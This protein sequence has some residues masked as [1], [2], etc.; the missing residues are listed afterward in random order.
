MTQ[1]QAAFVSEAL[2]ALC[3]R[4]SDRPFYS[5]Q[6]LERKLKVAQQKDPLYGHLLM[7]RNEDEILRHE[8]QEIFTRARL[9]ERQAS[10]LT[11]RLDGFTFEEIGRR[12]GHTKQGAQSIFLQALKKL[13]R[14]FR[15]YPFRGLNEVYRQELKRG[16]RSRS[17]GTM[18]AGAS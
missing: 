13:T 8:C 10:V 18:S 15:V 6:M 2:L 12:G 3:E 17:F 9:T 1:E 11:M 14:A 7:G 16:V 5:E 4:S